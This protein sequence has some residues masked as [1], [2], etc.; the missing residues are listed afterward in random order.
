M[1]E[2][3]V[4]YSQWIS[5]P[6]RD[7][8]QR[9]TIFIFVPKVSDEVGDDWVFRQAFDSYPV[10][11]G[12]YR[13]SRIGLAN[14]EDA[15]AEAT[16]LTDRISDLLDFGTLDLH[17]AILMGRLDHFHPRTKYRHWPSRYQ[18]LPLSFAWA[19]M[20]DGDPIAYYGTSGQGN[21]DAHLLAA[22][23][24]RSVP[25]RRSRLPA[26]GAKAGFCVECG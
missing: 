26:V 15:E 21:E 13:S 14:D 12:V 7:A 19:A 2:V 20:S 16:S 24:P 11:S 5:N 23:W 17:S 6:I 8:D 25:P 1:S 9:W 18:F 3:E 4:V 22:C 10:V